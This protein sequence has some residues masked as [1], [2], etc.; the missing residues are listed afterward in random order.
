[1]PSRSSRLEGLA[2]VALSR[3]QSYACAR[4]LLR[5]CCTLLEDRRGGLLRRSGSIAC[6]PRPLLQVLEQGC[7]IFLA[8]P[9]RSERAV[10]DAHLQAGLAL[11]EPVSTMTS[12]SRR[13]RPHTIRPAAS[14][15]LAAV[16]SFGPHCVRQSGPASSPQTRTLLRPRTPP[17]LA[18]SPFPPSFPPDTSMSPSSREATLRRFPRASSTSSQ[19]RGLR[20]RVTLTG[21]WTNGRTVSSPMSR[22]AT[23]A[24]P[25]A[26]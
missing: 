20:F 6:S 7:K 5:H 19:D 16:T 25:C 9:G 22:R 1:M 2:R 3:A 4:S 11:A 21:P 13:T 17:P 24:C 14:H 15:P 12:T 8:T 10:G 18:P 23:T 26:P